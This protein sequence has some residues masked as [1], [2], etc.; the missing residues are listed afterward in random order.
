MQSM[1]RFWAWSALVLWVAFSA[2]TFADTAEPAEV[3]EVVA[4][5]P[6]ELPAI[7]N[8]LIAT[9][10]PDLK[11]MVEGQ[12]VNDAGVVRNQDG[13]VFVRAEPIFAALNDDYEYDAG[14]G[15][16][17][18]RRS[19][20]GVVMELYTNDG[21]VKANGKPIGKLRIFGEVTSD[22]ITLTPNAIAVLAGAKPKH[23]KMTGILHF[24]LDARLRV[25]SGF[26]LYIDDQL[27]IIDGPQAKSVGPVLLLPLLP[28]AK[29]L[30]HYTQVAP[31][32]SSV[33]IRRAQDSATFEMDLNTGLVK[34][35]G[36]PIG[37]SK[38]VT[39]ID[40]V[41]LLL[42]VSAIE[43]LTGT[44][45]KVEA[46]TDR[47]DI[48][49]DDRL[50]DSI[51]PVDR[52][53]DLA[54]KEPL[55]VERLAFHVGADTINEVSST[56]RMKKING[57]IRYEVPDLPESAGEL[58]PSWLSLDYRHL[59]GAYG[60][61]GD[62][63]A[64]LRQ[65]DGVGL[66]RVRGI[67]VTKES[68]DARWSGVIGAPVIGA[69][70]IS[71]DQSRL[72]FGGIAAGLRYADKAGWEAGVSLK[73][74][75]LSGDQMAVL[76]AISG[77]LGRIQNANKSWDLN[78]DLGVFNGPARDKSV[79]VRLRGTG[80]YQ[81][82]EQLDIDAT[83]SYTGAEFLR[84]DL[85][86]EDLAESLIEGEDNQVT[87]TIPDARR[88]GAD[89]MTVSAFT[90]YSA[91]K[92]FG[93]LKHPGVSA[94]VQKSVIGVSTG[95]ESRVDTLSYGAT[96]S[97]TIGEK[98][99]NVTVDYTA[100]S[101]EFKADPA[102][103]ETGSALSVRAYQTFEHASVRGQ[104]TS[105][106]INGGDARQR[107]DISINSKPVT[108]QGTKESSLRIAPSVSASW[109]PAG[110]FARGGVVAHV[111]SGQIFGPKTRAQASLGVLQPFGGDE[112]SKADS[113]FTMSIG[114]QLKINDNLALSLAYRNDLK[115]E[116][117]FG[118]HLDG[119]YDFNEARKYKKTEDGRGVLKG[120][121]FLDNNRD[122]IKQQDEPGIGGA[123][124]RIK[125][126]GRKLAL[127]SDS[128][129]YFTVQNIKQGIHEV[130]IDA[131]S[132]PLGYALSEDILSRA[133]VRE[134]F[135]TDI[136][137]PI[138]QRGQI[139]GFAFVD[140]DADGQYRN[141]ESRLEGARL[142]LVSTSDSGEEYEAVSTSFGQYAF[143]DLP[144]GDYS[145]SI[146]ATNSPDAAPGEPV[147]V[148]LAGSED[149]MT[150]APIGAVAVSRK[151]LAVKE[152]PPDKTEQGEKTGVKTPAPPP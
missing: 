3:A 89:Q 108:F 15:A 47:V 66:R 14:E 42:P 112:N 128:A 7:K 67:S 37:V 114:R 20:D 40:A 135:I 138:V 41:N 111:D 74:D 17:I 36:R 53:E 56:F 122:G 57:R 44:H 134:G 86:A 99:P 88:K 4:A 62:L 84:N 35:G 63:T 106:V 113:Y 72:K 50:T 6:A 98:G 38:D 104:Y 92:D 34:Q 109:S 8:K 130:S 116:Q 21:L 18:V 51:A 146:V 45:I 29:E 27:L 28:I 81:V 103:D 150:R 149:L 124:V 33:T 2:S 22:S 48:R 79:D 137:L 120:R 78:A 115:G 19:Q 129:G 144:P 142:R 87:E 132:L 94:R 100:Y 26:Q 85:D 69:A 93:V 60:S 13:H 133:T 96:A 141:S 117:R 119:R 39:Y 83:V 95:S 32:F 91:G 31:D 70:Q 9:P 148:T 23:D 77:K 110:T 97:A 145:L 125:G 147:L 82:T 43:T 24:E 55:T 10:E 54:A 1:L 61:V 139:R 49:L 140:S 123:I 118:I 107:A 58:E 68:K 131:R 65:L 12:S 46:G 143:D 105:Q 126:A 76:S 5:K 152:P 73:E 127:K 11:V 71:D 52:V 75:S 101:Q 151:E 102:Q 121:A 16:L 59:D 136:D 25:A 64:D 30:G 80:R 90:H